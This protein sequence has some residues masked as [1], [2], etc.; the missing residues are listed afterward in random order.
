[1]NTEVGLLIGNNVPKAMEPLQVINSQNEGPFACRSII[2]WMVFGC[3]KPEGS[4]SKILTE[5]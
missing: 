4:K 5:R 2:G 1:M 3:T